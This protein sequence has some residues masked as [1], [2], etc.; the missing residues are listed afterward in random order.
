VSEQS[1]ELLDWIAACTLCHLCGKERA[2]AVLS[3]PHFSIANCGLAPQLRY[4]ED[5][6][7][8]EVSGHTAAKLITL[9][10]HEHKDS[11]A[12]NET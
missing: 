2:Q 9:A 3:S 6:S 5:K 8:C 10:N 11:R 1:L 4:D 12:C 7:E